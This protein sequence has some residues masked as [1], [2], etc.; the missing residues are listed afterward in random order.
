[1]MSRERSA[2]EVA[3]QRSAVRHETIRIIL[4]DD[5]A[6]VRSGL[7]VLI[8]TQKDMEVVGEAEDGE[9][10]LAT[11]SRLRPDLVLLDLQ[12]PKV[13]G[14]EVIARIR[15]LDPA[16][17]IVV[18]TTFAGDA[19]ANRALQAGAS[20]YLLKSCH[21]HELFD[22]IRS[23]RAGIRRLDMEIAR[24]LSLHGNDQL[25][26]RECEIVRLAGAGRSNREIANVL[27]LTEDTIKGYMKIIFLK[28]GAADRAHAVTIAVRRGF[29][30][31]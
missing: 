1:M 14:V 30:S 21:R 27:L 15:R 5:H 28:L 3:P 13:D 8:A 31:L 24:G 20:G 12:M 11:F 10:A 22:A 23:A 29:I 26:E 9:Q 4:A 7:S 17:R 6:I 16:A 2:G 25:T 18:L 19:Q